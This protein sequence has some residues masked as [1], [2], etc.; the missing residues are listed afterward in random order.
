MAYD[1]DSFLAGVAA[2]RNMKS[3]P[4]LEKTGESVFIFT[5]NMHGIPG[6]TVES[7]YRQISTVFVGHVYWGD[8]T[9]EDWDGINNERQRNTLYH[10]YHVSGE[11]TEYTIILHGLI[12]SISFAPYRQ[13]AS[14]VPNPVK[15]ILTPL[16]PLP[17]VSHPPYHLSFTWMFEYC[18][19]LVSLPNGLF[20]N[21]AVPG[22]Y[23]ADLYRMFYE[24]SSLPA[25]PDKL[26]ASIQFEQYGAET[27][28]G[29]TR[30]ALDATELCYGCKSLTS[31]P[32]NLFGGNESAALITNLRQAFS[33]TG[34]TRIPDGV[35]NKLSGLR[36]AYAI[37]YGD[38][39]VPSQ[40]A[41][42]PAQLFD[43]CTALEDIDLGFSGCRKITSNVP[44]LWESHPDISH[45]SC[46][47]GCTNAA[48]Y[49]DIPADW[50]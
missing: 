24:C 28:G 46:F 41:Y 20:D 36:H 25:L 47:Y 42:V 10:V 33:R 23:V 14:F 22:V 15:S 6:T 21:Y 17:D 29:I 18:E 39:G 8:D 44:P 7:V 45:R 48:N 50:R 12:Y 34:L 30:P 1:R 49:G 3:W 35:F 13:S 27:S 11:Y 19:Q 26:F 43:N 38:S 2:G 4:A 40:I 9:D 37:F 5:V 32:G 16:P 31:I